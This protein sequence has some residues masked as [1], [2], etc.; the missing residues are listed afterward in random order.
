MLVDQH[1][2]ARIDQALDARSGAMPRNAGNSI[3]KP[4]GSSTVFTEPS[5]AISSAVILPARSWRS[6]RWS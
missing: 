1:E 3:E 6:G 4:N 5:S 2:A